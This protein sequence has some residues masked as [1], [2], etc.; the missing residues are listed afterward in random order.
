MQQTTCVHNKHN[1]LPT[2][3]NV[4]HTFTRFATTCVCDQVWFH[5][6]AVACDRKWTDVHIRTQQLQTHTCRRAKQTPH[7]ARAPA[8]CRRERCQ[9]WRAES[10][11]KGSM[12]LLN[13]FDLLTGLTLCATMHSC[14][15]LA[16][17][18]V[19]AVCDT[20]LGIHV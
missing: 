1:V 18:Y 4:T 8:V 15:L 14:A 19:S 11:Q 12:A 20:T 16:L 3:T 9:T 10:D 7:L 6:R 17:V 5:P 2:N 13:R